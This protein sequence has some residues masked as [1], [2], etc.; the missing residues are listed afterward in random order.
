MGTNSSPLAALPEDDACKS[1]RQHQNAVMCLRVRGDVARDAKHPKAHGSSHYTFSSLFSWRAASCTAAAASQTYSDAR[2]HR[3]GKSGY[4]C[5]HSLLYCQ[6]RWGP[7][8]RVQKGLGKEIRGEWV[9]VLQW[10][11]SN[12]QVGKRRGSQSWLPLS[13][14]SLGRCCKAALCFSRL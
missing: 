4:I 14:Q 12:W 11:G 10:T 13:P 1:A 3:K 5:K 8:P 7:G 6:T 2:V 9:I